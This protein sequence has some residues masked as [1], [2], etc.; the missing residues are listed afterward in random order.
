[1][2]LKS[3]LRDPPLG[4]RLGGLVQA[5]HRIDHRT[6]F[7]VPAVS[8]RLESPADRD[9]TPGPNQQA[10]VDDLH[11]PVIASNFHRL[12]PIVP[13]RSRRPAKADLAI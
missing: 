2:Y 6:R 3:R 10:C 4:M 8:T 12:E 13:L 9:M 7:S 5:R 1:M 11:R